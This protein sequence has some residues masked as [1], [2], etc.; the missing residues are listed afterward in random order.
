MASTGQTPPRR[1]LFTDQRGSGLR[2]SWHEERETVVLSLWREDVCVGT[3]Q[4]RPEDARRF[5]AFLTGHVDQAAER[6]AG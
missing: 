3:F 1:A 2:A 5:A 4:L 6:K